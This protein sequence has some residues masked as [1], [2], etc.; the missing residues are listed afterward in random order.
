MAIEPNPNRT[1][2]RGAPSDVPVETVYG[3][4]FLEDRLIRLGAFVTRY[5][6]PRWG[7]G[8]ILLSDPLEIH[9]AHTKEQVESVVSS[10]FGTGTSAILLPYEA[11]GA[12]HSHLEMGDPGVPFYAWVGRYEA[13][14]NFYKELLPPGA[15]P[16]LQPLESDFDGEGYAQAFRAVKES[17]AVGECYQVNLTERLRYRWEGS[18]WSLFVSRAGVDPPPYATFVHGGDWQV[19]SWSPELFVEQK[20]SRARMKPMK[21]TAPRESRRGDLLTPKTFA[22]NLMIL[23]MVRNDLG[24]LAAIGSVSVSSLFDIEPHR[25]VW[26]MTSTVE[27][28]VSSGL[29]LL[30]A[31]FPPASVTGAPKSS[32]CAVIQQL[33]RS[34]RGLYCGAL[35]FV[36]GSG[37]MRLSVGIRTAFLEGGTATYGVGSGIVWESDLT[38]EYEEWRLKSVA[39]LSGAEQWALLETMDPEALS[40]PTR[41]AAHLTRLSRSGAAFGFQVDLLEIN[42][43]L[44]D[45]RA[46]SPKQSRLRLTYS[47]PGTANVAIYPA[48]LPDRDITF[49]I[50]KWPVCSQDP[51]LVHK[52]T[53]RQVYQEHL[54]AAP[55]CDEVLLYNERGELTEFTTGALLIRIGEDWVTPPV[56]CGCLPSIGIGS[57]PAIRRAITL[58]DLGLADGVWMVNARGRWRGILMATGYSTPLPDAYFNEG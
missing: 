55:D 46:D 30:K 50:A 35:G 32:A 44:T 54:D 45:I 2:G 14:A 1:S 24:S 13:V 12:F 37:D 8:W 3:G 43:C 27:A 29:E 23:D 53:S 34:P 58:E 15:T 6:D 33:E 17:L 5:R 40:E 31:V 4:Y 19:A 41:L 56:S 48:R 39:F 38:A 49:R 7:L 28:N 22:E 26:Q 18:S 10:A 16:T 20:G 42:G 52:T 47:G 21:G 11:A 25:S 36:C 51:A 9:V 57:V